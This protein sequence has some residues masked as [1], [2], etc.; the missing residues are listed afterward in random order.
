[1]LTRREFIVAVAAALAL[2]VTPVAQGQ[3]ITYWRRDEA[4]V[5]RFHR[6]VNDDFPDLSDGRISEIGVWDCALSEDELR[7][8]E[9][10]APTHVRPGN[11]TYYLPLHGVVTC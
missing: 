11:L 4:N 7:A 8:L 5:W 10:L 1:M 9:T 3:T 2:P 6:A